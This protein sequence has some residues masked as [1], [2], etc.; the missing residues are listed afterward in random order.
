MKK[1]ISNVITVSAWSLAILTLCMLGAEPSGSSE[2]AIER[3]EASAAEWGPIALKCWCYL[4][5]TLVS[6]LLINKNLTKKA[7]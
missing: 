5:I 6:A 1:L 7:A 3:Y 2:A 4:A